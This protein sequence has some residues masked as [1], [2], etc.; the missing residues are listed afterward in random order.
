MAQRIVLVDDFDGTDAEE[1]VQFALDGVSYEI[2]LSA[3]H[4]GGLRE[5]LEAYVNAARRTGGRKVA[6]AGTSSAT[7]TAVAGRRRRSGQTSGVSD[8]DIRAWAQSNGVDVSAKGRVS[9][10]VREQY[11]AAV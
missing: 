4:A 5:T 1:T 10:S 3:E 2:D 6:A 11:L 7:V 9:K 8:S